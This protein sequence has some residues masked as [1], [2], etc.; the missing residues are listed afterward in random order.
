MFEKS[1]SVDESWL[2]AMS[3]AALAKI[4]TFKGDLVS[5]KKHTELLERLGGEDSVEQ[6]WLDQ[7]DSCLNRL[8]SS[9]DECE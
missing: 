6:A 1:W 5:A 2:D 8:K 9:N 7:I 3:H 4:H